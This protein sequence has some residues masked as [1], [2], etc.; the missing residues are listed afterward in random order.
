MKKKTPTIDLGA[1]VDCEACL[2]LCPGVFR[3]NDAG[4]IEVV[5]LDEY[6][7]DQIQEAIADCPANCI[8]WL[9]DA[10]DSDD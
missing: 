8:S 10:G 9:E 7:E 1:C 3:R 4:Y 6:P 2:E 5:D